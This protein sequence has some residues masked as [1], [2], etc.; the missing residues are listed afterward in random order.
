MRTRVRT[1][2]V[3]ELVSIMLTFLLAR[4]RAEIRVVDVGL[5]DLVDFDELFVDVG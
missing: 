1:R 2:V 3:S 4:W 5:D